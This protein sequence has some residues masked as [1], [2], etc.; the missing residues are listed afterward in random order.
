[1]GSERDAGQVTVSSEI[2]R[3]GKL[4]LIRGN[5]VGFT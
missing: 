2:L 1:M 3:F 5:S 4:S